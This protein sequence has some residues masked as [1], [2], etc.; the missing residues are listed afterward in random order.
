MSTAIISIVIYE[1]TFNSNENK[2][3]DKNLKDLNKL[4]KNGCK[5]PCY[6]HKRNSTKSIDTNTGIFFVM[7]KLR[8]HFN[9]KTHQK[10]LEYYNKN[11][12]F[13]DINTKTFEELKADYIKLIKENRKNIADMKSSYE[14]KEKELIKEK[15]TTINILT[16]EI[17]DLKIKYNYLENKLYKTEQDLINFDLN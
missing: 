15:N 9:T 2:F 11:N 12:Q 8:N 14:E 3:E 13:N 6:D 1:P 7:H 10:W 17:S 4:Y 16:K 5:C